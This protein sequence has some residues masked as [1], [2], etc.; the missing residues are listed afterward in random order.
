MGSFETYCNGQSKAKTHTCAVR[1]R[2]SKGVDP[3]QAIEQKQTVGVDM[4]SYPL[5]QVEGELLRVL[6]N[7]G[8][9]GRGSTPNVCGG[10]SSS[11]GITPLAVP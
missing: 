9:L 2:D 6:V 7:G 5:F 1:N 3:G 11:C 4:K 8:A 10:Y